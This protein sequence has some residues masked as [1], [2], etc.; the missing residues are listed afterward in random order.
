MQRMKRTECGKAQVRGEPSTGR[1]R[2]GTVITLV[3]HS[4]E[5]QLRR[6]SK[7]IQN[8]QKA[9]TTAPTNQKPTS[10]T[11]S[12]DKPELVR[13]KAQ[14]S[15]SFK[16]LKKAGDGGVSSQVPSPQ[17]KDKDKDLVKT[18]HPMVKV[19]V[20]PPPPTT[21]Q[22]APS[23][24]LKPELSLWKRIKKMSSVKITSAWKT[25]QKLEMR[26]N[27]RTERKGPQKH[28]QDCSSSE[29]PSSN[30]IPNLI[31]RPSTTK[32]SSI[33]H[34]DSVSTIDPMSAKND[35]VELPPLTPRSLTDSLNQVQEKEEEEDSPQVLTDSS[36]LSPKALSC[37]MENG[38]EPSS[39]GESHDVSDYAPPNPPPLTQFESCS[40]QCPE[41][42][43]EGDSSSISS[44][45]VDQPTCKTPTTHG[46]MIFESMSSE[47]PDLLLISNS[48][49]SD[50]SQRYG[51][52]HL[53]NMPSMENNLDCIGVSVKNSLRKV[54]S[55]CV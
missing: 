52:L 32:S 9:N 33:A 31:D 20:Q 35:P 51:P 21:T 17:T 44:S 18:P 50:L 22:K 3:N 14:K 27:A 26:K 2:R 15:S 43:Q 12:K 30:T 55:L 16:T 39:E 28:E 19:V 11:T 29:R 13:G 46:S 7:P 23:S 54:E 24:D 53:P 10:S 1:S 37:V 25:D 36:D 48:E 34:D 40:V 49:N 38:G 5:S 45:P 41:K 6:H 47:S 8:T 4:P 42:L